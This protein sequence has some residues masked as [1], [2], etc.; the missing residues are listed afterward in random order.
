MVG[1]DS[2]PPQDEGASDP[3]E[4]PTGHAIAC[5]EFAGTATH[6]QPE[7]GAIMSFVQRPTET[8]VENRGEG[9]SGEAQ[10]DAYAVFSPQGPVKRQTWRESLWWQPAQAEPKDVEAALPTQDDT[11]LPA[12]NSSA[13]SALPGNVTQA[14]DPY[15]YEFR[16]PSASESPSE[17]GTVPDLEDMDHDAQG[18]PFKSQ[19]S[20]TLYQDDKENPEPPPTVEDAGATSAIAPTHPNHRH[21]FEQSGELTDLPENENVDPYD[22]YEVAVGPAGGRMA[23]WDA[24][25]S[26]TRFVKVPKDPMFDAQIEAMISDTGVSWLEAVETLLSFRGK[27]MMI[28]RFGEQDGSGPMDP[29]WEAYQFLQ[30]DGSKWE[31]L[32]RPIP[33]DAEGKPIPPE[34]KLK[35]RPRVATKLEHLHPVIQVQVTE[36]MEQCDLS[37]L[38][39]LEIVVGDAAKS[40]EQLEQAEVD[41]KQ[42]EIREA[43]D[44]D[45]LVKEYAKEDDEWMYDESDDGFDTAVE[46]PESNMDGETEG[47]E[48]DDEKDGETKSDSLNSSSDH[49]EGGVAL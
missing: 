34:T 25:G 41:R 30:P 7:M 45:A 13:Q 42:H 22:Y 24:L 1:L 23:S 31:G 27:S 28:R 38:E 35:L 2:P 3:H 11:V 15:W 16:Q 18:M 6:H 40:E 33:V 44:I 43:H 19:V 17:Q 8:A 20:V 14:K 32:P 12:Q 9:R 48:G 39:A 29:K 47:G 10:Q 5:A 37:F 26:D 46:D 21:P 4:Q 49:E 36:L